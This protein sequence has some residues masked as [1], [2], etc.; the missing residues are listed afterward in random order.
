[1]KKDCWENLPGSSTHG[2]K[3]TSFLKPQ[4]PHLYNRDCKPSV[5]G[6]VLQSL[7]KVVCEQ[8]LGT[9]HDRPWTAGLKSKQLRV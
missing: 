5:T 2:E 7:N 6:R 8:G 1:M 9:A 3:V 4:P